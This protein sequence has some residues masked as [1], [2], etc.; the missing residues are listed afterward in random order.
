[1]RELMKRTI[2]PALLLVALFAAACHDDAAK[3]SGV[4]SSTVEPT[5]AAGGMATAEAAT[6]ATSS[7][8]APTP[9]TVVRDTE[10]KDKPYADAKTLKR[11]PARTAVTIVDRQGGWLRVQA[12]GQQGW[13]RLLHV[14]SQSAGGSKSGADELKSAANVA[15][16]RAGAG[17]IVSTTG[18]R[19][20]NEEQLSKAQPNPAELQRLES[21]G[22]SKE[23]AAA[24]ARSHKLDRRQVAYVAEP[25]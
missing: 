25:R 10:L 12:G 11:L 24:Y 9:A 13:V 16:G 17:N 14:S 2:T 8:L 1:M 23:Q 22:A 15:T 5:P 7:K 19:G 6:P 18:I 21:Y 4:P 20:L 3:K